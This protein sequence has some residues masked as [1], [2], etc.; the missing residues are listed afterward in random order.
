M[1]NLRLVTMVLAFLSMTLMPTNMVALASPGSW[2]ADY[3]AN[4]NLEGAPVLSRADGSINFDW[5]GG[6]PDP[7]VPADNFSV[8]WTRDE[9]FAGG[10][11]RFTV[12]SD[13]GIRLWVNGELLIDE[14]HDREAAWI[15]VDHFVPQGTWPVVVEY[16][17]HG[18]GA[19][20][21]VKAL[22]L[23]IAL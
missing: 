16:Y 20:A 19:V 9:W 12:R 14:W 13:D 4:P 11:F 6:S 8:R 10:T 17:E 23:Q 22:H 3:F 7:A 18:G 1:K 15:V 2:W 5:G 21:Q